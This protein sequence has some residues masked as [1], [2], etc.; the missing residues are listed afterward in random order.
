MKKI[1]LS[2][3]LV[4]MLIAAFITFQI[5][6]VTLTEKYEDVI[7]DFNKW[8]EMT[9]Y[10][11]ETAKITSLDDNSKWEDIYTTLAEVDR[12]VRANY[13]GEIDEDKLL[14]Y[15]MA[16]YFYG[17]GDK[18]SAYMNKDEYA[19]Y[20]MSMNE[21]AFVGIGV[22]ITYDN[23]MGGMYVTSV[24]PDSPAETVGILPG[25]LIVSVE[26]NNV[27]EYGYYNAYNII[28]NG[29]EN[30][31]V[32]ITIATAI[33]QYTQTA[34]VQL[35]RQVIKK[36][37]VQGKILTGNIAYVKI[38]EFD[39]NTPTDFVAKMK[40]LKVNGATKFI[41]DVRNNPG[42]SVTS[43]T[44]V[45]DYLLPEGPVIRRFSKSG[46]VNYYN[47]DANELSAP[48]VV[49]TNGNTAS[50]GE[51]FTAALRDYD[52]ATVIGT[53]TYGKGTVQTIMPLNSGGGI[54]ISTETYNPPKSDNYE[55]IGI[56]PDIVVELPD[57]LMARFYSLSEKEDLQL[58][59][60]LDTIKEMK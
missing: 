13:I 51:L 33:S 29:S 31:P 55:G 3:C 28:K 45:L 53:T 17:T 32:N 58:Q 18:Y 14:E 1:S 52:K 26:G 23:T 56:I 25:D 22:R 5:T 50:G 8:N 42:G 12:N 4:L 47:S 2:V 16:G 24:I 30:E 38:L 10:L 41:F 6:Y 48:M 49:I 11:D 20:I 19:A 43:V 36:D 37:T 44:G 15:I 9:S 57:E 34:D 54:K 39:E 35:L 59:A 27:D 40:E 60:A 7:Y 21:G 46:E